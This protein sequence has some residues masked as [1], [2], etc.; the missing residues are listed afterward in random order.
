MGPRTPQTSIKTTAK[1]HIERGEA[2]FD[3]IRIEV[4]TV[5]EVPGAETDANAFRNAAEG[6]KDAQ[7]P[8]L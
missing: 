3:I 5:S 6:S 4:D 7:F 1:V 8:T 2:G